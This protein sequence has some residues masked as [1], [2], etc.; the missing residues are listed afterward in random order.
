MDVTSGSIFG[1]FTYFK[2]TLSSRMQ[3]PFLEWQLPNLDPDP[4]LAANTD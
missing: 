1:P 2:H 4:E 3:P